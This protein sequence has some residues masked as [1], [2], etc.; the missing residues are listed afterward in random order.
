MKAGDAA[1]KEARH[2]QAQ[3][4]IAA[5]EH[6]ESRGFFFACPCVVYPL[7]IES[8]CAEG[9]RESRWQSE[10][11]ACCPRARDTFCLGTPLLWCHRSQFRVDFHSELNA[12]TND[13][14]T[15]WSASS[16]ATS[17][18]ASST[19]NRL[20]RAR[21]RSLTSSK[22]TRQPQMASMLAFWCA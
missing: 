22:S 20:R 14:T 3:P 2:R 11:A 4:R 5:L 6:A 16:I 17:S 9:K 10:D 19:P 8:V 13:T 18:S 12:T 21:H 1:S 7:E 15:T